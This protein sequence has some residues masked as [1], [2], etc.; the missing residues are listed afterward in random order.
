V[1]KW[2]V[3]TRF[4]KFG[5]PDGGREGRGVVP[6]GD[7]WAWQA[8]YVRSYDSSTAA[9]VRESFLRT[10]ETEPRLRR[11]FVTM[12]LDLPA[13]DTPKTKSAFTRWEEE[14]RKLEEAADDLDRAVKV[15]FISAHDLTNALTLDHN[16]GRVRYWFDAGALSQTQQQERLDDVAAKLG[17]RYSPQLHVDVDVVQV[18]EGAGRNAAYIARW[19]RLLADLRSARRWSWRAPEGDE[20]AFHEALKICES[21][22]DAVDAVF[23]GIVAQLRTLDA[24]DVATQQIDA[25]VAALEGVEKILRQR[26]RTDDGFYVGDAGTLYGNV[27]DANA[28]LYNA[29][30][31]SASPATA[32]AIRGELLLTGRAG[33][34]KSHLLCDAAMQRVAEGR[35]T[36]MVLGQDFDGRNLLTQLPE[37]AETPE[38]VDGLLGLLN[39]AAE[40]SGHQALLIVDAVNESDQPDRWSS[41]LRAMRSKFSRYPGVSLI[42]SCRTEFIEAV[43]GDH[44]LPASEHY[45]FEESTEAAVRRF[46]DE[47]GLDVPTFPLFN[48]EF[49]NPLFLRLTCEALT[50]LGAGRFTLG[51]AGLTTVCEA[52]I[53]AANLRLAVGSR[54]DFD[55][56]TDLVG[57]AVRQLAEIGGGRVPRSTAEELCSALLPSRPWSKSLLK[58]M[59]DEGVL[60]EAGRDHISF[61]Y[62]R[63]GDVARA[64]T[65]SSQ[66]PAEVTE[67]MRSLGN[68]LWIERGVLGA[69]SV[70]MPEVHSVELVDCADPTKPA[71]HELVDAF[72]ESISLRHPTAT[73]DRAE[74]L[75]RALLTSDRHRDETWRQLIRVA[76]VPGHPLNARWLHARLSSLELPLRDR[77]W[78]LSLIG[79]LDPDEH[80]PIRTLLEWAW[81]VVQGQGAR[82]IGGTA[83]LALLV[84]GWCTSTTDRQVRDGASK[85]LVSIGER[86]AEAFASAVSLLVTVNDPYVVERVVAAACGIALRRKALAS[87]LAVP[88]AAWVANG[89]PN[90]L[91]IRDYLRRVLEIAAASGWDGPAGQPPYGASWPIQSTPRDEIERLTA[92]PKYEYGSIWHSVTDM[93]DFGRYKLEPALRNFV[94]TDQRGLQASVEEAIFDRVRTL[95]WTPEAFDEIDQRLSRGRSGAPVERIGKKY[96]WIALYEVL[97]VVSDNLALRERWGSNPPY[98]Y[99]HAE[100]LIWRDIDVTVLVRDPGEPSSAGDAPWYSPSRAAFPREVVHD[101]PEDLDGVPDPLDLLAVTAPDTTQWITLLSAPGWKQEH[102]PEIAALRPPTRDSWMQLHGYLIPLGAA[103]K[104][105]T[106]A[107]EKD[108]YGRWMPDWADMANVLLGAHPTAP[109]WK[110]AEGDIDDW[111]DR[112]GGEPPT[113]LFQAGAWYGGTGTDGDASADE[114]TRA[115]LPSRKLMEMLKLESRGDFEWWDDA[116]VAVF[117]P[118]PKSGAP[119]ALLLRRD[120]LHRIEDAGYELFWT[121]L[122]G[123]EHF[124]PE[125]GAPRSDYRWITA[126]ASYRVAENQL[127]LVHSL[128]TLFKVGPEKVRTLA[129]N[130]K[131][132]ESDV[133]G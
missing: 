24:V 109:E 81:P 28:A 34:G 106:W 56:R 5:T 115:F 12:P 93:G 46:A 98:A 97:G 6:D 122:V 77:M 26:S 125:H 130:I 51:S 110:A 128:A 127:E 116:G 10:L 133:R 121:A 25:A 101:Y 124:V 47:Y 42:I 7:V 114:E 8:K 11:Y 43:V 1:V 87:Q 111:D 112:S 32:A 63:L 107:Q 48:P 20:A 95:G 29:Q 57:A 83:E 27:R 131:T 92:R 84:L 40:A 68:R 89:W 61:G 91:L 72:L 67:W 35:P 9:Q 3:G 105:A 118:A 119:N 104:W 60:V 129:W 65:I 132:R 99:T 120:L 86:E 88:L 36:V 69:L 54:C 66:S 50:T 80:S 113:E 82:I 45:G 17:R 16:A 23:E 18:V 126:S 108:W 15:E 78:S 41:A 117:D 59:L 73:G 22:L 71:P 39:A 13:G 2:P 30:R 103:S 70:L 49:G 37:L 4:A 44:G 52:F 64:K 31:L 19:Q 62:Q 55:T 38:N 76:C 102:P 100:Q 96:Q 21:A 74:E 79:A 85:A 75:V 53:E 123:H 33:V 14:A 94:T 58:G 90:H